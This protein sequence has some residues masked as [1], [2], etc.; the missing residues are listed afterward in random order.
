MLRRRQQGSLQFCEVLVLQNRF[1]DLLI[2]RSH[3]Y[4][5][6]L[7]DGWGG[8]GYQTKYIP[9]NGSRTSRSTRGVSYIINSYLHYITIK[10]CSTVW[11]I[12]RV[13]L[14]IRIWHLR[15][16]IWTSD[17]VVVKHHTHCPIVNGVLPVPIREPNVSDIPQSF[18]ACICPSQQ[19][20]F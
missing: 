12:S 20:I 2:F 14:I 3:K 16:L 7:G 1:N 19:S 4:C 11:M 9:R 5:L 18:S 17:T 13:G 8:R 6:L 15:R 10:I